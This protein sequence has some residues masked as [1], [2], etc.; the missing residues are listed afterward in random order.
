[1]VNDEVLKSLSINCRELQG[2]DIGG[3][4]NVSDEGLAFLS[5]MNIKWLRISRTQVL[6]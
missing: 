5:E 6:F 4:V 2:L 1:M 3:C